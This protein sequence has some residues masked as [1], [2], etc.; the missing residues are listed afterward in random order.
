MDELE[1]FTDLSDDANLQLPSPELVNTYKDLKERIYWIDREIDGGMFSLIQYILQWNRED[2]DIPIDQRKPI[3]LFFFSQ[4]GSLDVEEALV[5]M[6]KISKTPIYGI[7]LGMVA[8][9][10]SMIFLACQKRYALPNTYLLIHQGSA[11]M[12]GNYSEI[13]AAMKDYEEQVERMTSFYIANSNYT[14]E[15]IRENI[16]T[17]WYVRGEELKNRGL[18]TDWITDISLLI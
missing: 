1:I 9:A 13:A 10:A 3:R 16:K 17:D 8:S 12:N 2:K 15:E 11:K 18:I 7:A 5:S 14:E 6:I 4:G